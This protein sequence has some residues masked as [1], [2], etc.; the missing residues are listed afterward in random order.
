MDPYEIV[1]LSAIGFVTGLFSGMFGI[2]GGS[3]RI[4]LLFLAGMPLINAFATNMFAIPFCS[5]IGAHVQRKNIRW[6]IAAPFVLG[7]SIGIAAATLIVGFIS[8]HVLSLIF[9][10]AAIL[11]MLGL[12][13]DKISPAI[14]DKLEP[15]SQN[16]FIGGFFSNLIIGMRGGSGG[17]AFP[18]VLRAMHIKMH[19]AVA[20]S[21]FVGTITSIIALAIYLF[22]G[23]VL[24]FHAVVV[25]VAGVAGS[26]I[27]SKFSMETESKWLKAGLAAMVFLLACGVLYGEFII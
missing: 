7:A 24:L 10:F 15:T 4:P 23:E 1:I 26:Y 19:S 17:T 6:S 14:Y 21:L 20:T 8:T 5:A 12:Y 13:M 25:T 3:V 16:L 11:T 9:F 27:G 18:P 22:R 2:G